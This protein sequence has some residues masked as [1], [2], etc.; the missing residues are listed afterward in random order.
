[1]IAYLL[2]RDIYIY[3][4]IDIYTGILFFMIPALWFQIFDFKASQLLLLP[5]CIV[6]F[7]IYVILMRFYYL[8]ISLNEKCC[9]AYSI[10]AHDTTA[11]TILM[12]DWCISWKKTKTKTKTSPCQE[13][14]TSG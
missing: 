12:L 2:Y 10:Y 11:A 7:G 1:M 4:Y 5:V 3:R 13:P 6:V 8:Y 14:F 9:R